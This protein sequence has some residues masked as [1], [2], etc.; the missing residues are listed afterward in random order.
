MCACR[1]YSAIGVLVVRS[2]IGELILRSA[3]GMFVISEERRVG[4]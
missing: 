4:K 3:I 1:A 2:A